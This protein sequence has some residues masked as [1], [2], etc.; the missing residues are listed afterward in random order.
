MSLL[1]PQEIGVIV[2]LMSAGLKSDWLFLHGA[3]PVRAGW[4]V[5]LEDLNYRPSPGRRSLVRADSVIAAA[6]A[7]R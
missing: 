3:P 7:E 5:V 1:R 4:G 6:T 2:A